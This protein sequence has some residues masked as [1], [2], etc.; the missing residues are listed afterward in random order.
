MLTVGKLKCDRYL[1]FRPA[2]FVALIPELR[3][4]VNFGRKQHNNLFGEFP[5][6]AD[7]HP[8]TDKSLSNNNS[9]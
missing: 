6:I 3:F 5:V 1:L 2:I 8:R 7:T 9:E 4:M